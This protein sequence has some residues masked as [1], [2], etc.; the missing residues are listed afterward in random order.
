MSEKLFEFAAAFVAGKMSADDFA[1]TYQEMWKR[2]RDAGL[3]Q[4]DEAS[5]S[6]ACST[7]FI[8]ADQYNPDFDRDQEE[9]DETEL[10]QE[11]AKALATV[12]NQS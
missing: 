11:V 9:F 5:L 2:E 10:R 1:D 3:L 4:R 8:L 12:R 6:L 7:T